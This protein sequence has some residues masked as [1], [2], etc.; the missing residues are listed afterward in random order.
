MTEIM[1]GI[2]RSRENKNMREINDILNE[3]KKDIEDIKIELEKLKKYTKESTISFAKFAKSYRS[4]KNV[5]KAFD[6]YLSNK[7]LKNKN[8]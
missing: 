6:K 5:E 3:F 4:S 2:K 7:K 1:G 8:V